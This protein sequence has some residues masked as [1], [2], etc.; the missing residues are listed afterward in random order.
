MTETDAIVD[1]LQEALDLSAY[2]LL[3]YLLEISNPLSDVKDRAIAEILHRIAE[4]DRQD[5]EAIAVLICDLGGTP[6]TDTFDLDDAHYNYLTASYLLELV[7]KRLREQHLAFD[8]LA[9]TV[10]D[11]PR[12]AELLKTIAARRAKNEEA[13]QAAL[14][15][16]KKAA[17]PPPLKAAPAATATAKPGATAATPAAPGAPAAAKSAPAPAAKPPLD[18]A[19]LAALKAAAEA[20]KAALAAG[21]GGGEKPPA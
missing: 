7:A 2:S 10:A 14:A 19:K 20:K 17:A 3:T 16:A 18:P 21:S 5:R 13:L 15:A 1:T 11:E 12:A 9:S 4:E 6:A 8:R